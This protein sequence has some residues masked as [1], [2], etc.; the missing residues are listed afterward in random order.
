VKLPASAVLGVLRQVSHRLPVTSRQLRELLSLFET[1]AHRIDCVVLLYLQV[2]DLQSEKVFR[3]RF[4]EKS[5]LAQLR[6]RLGHLVF[7]PYM[8]PEQF[9]FE[10]DLAKHD[11]RL[12]ANVIFNLRSKEHLGAFRNPV[13]LREG[14]NVPLISGVP[15]TWE[16]MDKIPNSGFLSGTYK[17]SADDRKWQA[18]KALMQQ[19]GNWRCNFEKN[20]VMWWRG[21][22]EVPQDV[23]DFMEF[24]TG[25]FKDL[26]EPFSIIDGSGSSNSEIS[27]QE[28]IDGTERLNF[29]KF[30]GPLKAIRIERIFRF[31]DDATGLI[32]L[33]KWRA[34]QELWDELNLQVND[35]A[36]FAVRHF[37]Y[38]I[39][40]LERTWHALDSDASGMISSVEWN[41]VVP[42]GFGF[43]GPIATLFNFIDKDDEGTI[44]VQEF[45]AL[46]PSFEAYA[47]AALTRLT[48]HRDGQLAQWQKHLVER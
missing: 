31:L 43:F 47:D 42:E 12:A 6:Q 40:A 28:W 41:Q 1:S 45:N 7:L 3:V 23:L 33:D 9:E 2:V 46:R 13:F 32:T 17:V 5:E 36:G 15:R 10:F 44:S 21:A 27:L 22:A 24:L 48:K 4:E 14:V 26:Q 35:F 34:L 20:E 38:S 29:S 18:R 25:N 39:D 16:Y 19:F 11:Q 8:Q 30:D 37:D